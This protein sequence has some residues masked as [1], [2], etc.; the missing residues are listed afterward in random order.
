MFL[1]RFAFIGLGLLVLTF[2]GCGQNAGGLSQSGVLPNG[3]LHR[4]SSEHNLLYVT[5]EPGTVNFYSWPEG[6]YRGTL[7][8]NF[9]EPFGLCSDS[10]GNVFVTDYVRQLIFEY[11]HGAKK[12]FKELKPPR[13]WFDPSG[14]SVDPTTGNLAVTLNKSGVVIYPKAA[15]TP[16][17]YQ[18]S[19]FD[20]YAFCGYDGAG[21]LFV[22]GNGAGPSY[23][24]EFAELP[25]GGSTLKSGK[26]DQNIKWPGGVQWD[27]EY[28]TVGDYAKSVVYRFS[29]HGAKGTR[30]GWTP[31]LRAHQPQQYV[32]WG[33]RLI[34][35]SKAYY[36][37]STP[38]Q[39]L[40]YGYPAYSNARRSITKKVDYP[41][42]VTISAGS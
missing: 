14:C 36:S 41:N 28:L 5:N 38:S 31:L 11:A 1:K 40:I 30:I 24:F 2:A 34:A 26:L 18:N 19:S 29:M 13:G 32:I 10:A 3:R 16:A 20:E 7:S 21:N 37:S 4:S 35:P 25:A 17:T 27:G 23:P 12:H 22:D 8:G 9:T 33:A 42:A 6:S 15:G 39:L